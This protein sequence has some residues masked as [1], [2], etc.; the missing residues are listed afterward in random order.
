MADEF[1]S[2]LSAV[3]RIG[4]E[5]TAAAVF[6]PP[7]VEAGKTGVKQKRR[8]AKDGEKSLREAVEALGGVSEND[9]GEIKV[10]NT[11][12]DMEGLRWVFENLNDKKVRASDAPT[13]LWGTFLGVLRSSDDAAAKATLDFFRVV[14]KR[15]EE[16]EERWRDDGREI[17]DL[18][19]EVR[20]CGVSGADGKISSGVHRDE[21]VA[22]KV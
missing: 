10:G 3:V 21:R 13:K 18:I 15:V 19:Q 6:T 8:T 2:G 7:G 14:L 17:I 20:R 12:A 9:T 22:R 11:I 16:K 1:A 5:P 4:S